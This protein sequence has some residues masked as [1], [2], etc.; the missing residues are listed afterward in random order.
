MGTRFDE[1]LFV[2]EDSL[3]V[4]CAIKRAKRIVI[5]EKSLY[6]YFERT[7][8][9]SRVENFNE[10]VYTEI[11]AWKRICDLYIDNSKIQETCFAAYAIRCMRLVEKYLKD[12]NFRKNY[13]KKTLIEFRKHYKYVKRYVIKNIREKLKYDLFYF[14]PSFYSFLKKVLRLGI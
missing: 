9:A 3:F 1:S 6:F 12:K 10:K 8:S 14:S 2:G 11:Y 13:Y 5:N 4:A 7:G